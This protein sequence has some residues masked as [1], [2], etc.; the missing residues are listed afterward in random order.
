MYAYHSQSADLGYKAITITII[1]VLVHILHMQDFSPTT[2]NTVQLCVHVGVRLI[3]LCLL[4]STGADLLCI[5]QMREVLDQTWNYR[6]RWKFIGIEL[7]IDM[8]TL[9]AIGK[10]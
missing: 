7:G 10:K 3:V 5:A 8:G 1:L 9:D 6:A 2:V 4:R